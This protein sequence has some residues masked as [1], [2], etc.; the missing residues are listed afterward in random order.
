MGARLS[1]GVIMANPLIQQYPNL[2]RAALA[3]AHYVGKSQADAERA[4][5]VAC[6]QMDAETL[7][8][9]E[10][11]SVD[12]PDLDERVVDYAKSRGVKRG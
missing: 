5:E 10:A 3:A 1:G 2:F 9:A 11:A 4:L 7:A 12:M 8:G 6:R